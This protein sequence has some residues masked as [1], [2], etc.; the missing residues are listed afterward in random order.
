M[1]Q[2]ITTTW[3]HILKITNN[4]TIYDHSNLHVQTYGDSRSRNNSNAW[5]IFIYPAPHTRTH[6]HFFFLFFLWGGGNERHVDFL[7]VFIV[8]V[9]IYSSSHR[10][11]N[12][13][14][15][16]S[17]FIASSLFRLYSEQNSTPFTHGKGPFYY[18][19]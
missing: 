18:E 11:T 1:T 2:D 9:S 7:F 13:L 4:N 8:F 3:H 14:F 15:I 16:K 12:S 5:F 10:A 19:K 6:T 17:R